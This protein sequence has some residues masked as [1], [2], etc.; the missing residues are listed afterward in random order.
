MLTSAALKMCNKCNKYFGAEIGGFAKQQFET[1]STGQRRR[2]QMKS[3]LYRHKL[4]HRHTETQTDRRTD[5]RTVL[6]S[7]RSS[8]NAANALNSTM[9]MLNSGRTEIRIT[10][11]TSNTRRSSL[12]LTID[13]INVE[14]K[15]KK[16]V[17]KRKKT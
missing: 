2:S 10:A 3:R 4:T 17:K 1:C 5:R 15:I 7:T 12:G 16:N 13:V 8:Q 14:M 11:R 6:G 9:S